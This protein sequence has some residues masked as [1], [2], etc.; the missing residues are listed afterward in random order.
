MTHLGF[1]WKLLFAF[2]ATT[3][4]A[5]AVVAFVATRL[6]RASY[7]RSD[8][9]RLEQVLGQAQTAIQRRAELAARRLTAAAESDAATRIAIALNQPAEITSGVFLSEASA[10]ARAHELELLQIIADDG[11]VLSSAQWEARAGYR[12]ADLPKLASHPA[13]FVRVDQLLSGPVLAVEV[14]REVSVGARKLYLLGGYRLDES[15]INEL[16]QAGLEHVVLFRLGG[17][18]QLLATPEAKRPLEPAAVPDTRPSPSGRPRAANGGRSQGL[19]PDRRP[20]HYRPPA[21]SPAVQ[22]ALRRIAER[23]VLTNA[24][25]RQELGSGELPQSTAAATPIRDARGNTLGAFVV[26]VSGTERSQVIRSLYWAALVAGGLGLAV[27]LVL[28]VLLANRITAPVAELVRASGEVA[29]GNLDYRIRV[30]GD[31]EM[32][33]LSEAFNRMAASL[34]D[35]RERLVQAERVAAWRELARRLA[36]E[37]NNPLFP[38]QLSIEN[39]RR[40]R[41]LDPDNFSEVF[42]E[43]TT[44]LLAELEE[45]K[46]IV[47][48]FSDF[49]KMPRPEPEPTDLRELLETTARRYEARI[50]QEN[51][52]LNLRL[53]AEPVVAHAD[54]HLI[55]QALGNLVLNALDAMPGGGQLDL[56]AFRQ[57]ARA[58]VEVADTGQGLTAE[59]QQR[60]FTPYYTTKQHGT[61]LGLAIVQSV[62]ADHGGRIT[63]ESEPQ[64]GTRFR[65]ELPLSVAS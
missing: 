46:R 7:L 30:R 23:A 57:D 29:G 5:V 16:N 4:V 17:Q 20:G 52:S 41:Q 49:A 31:D 45:L 39:L 51:V 38:L 60:L 33:R 56:R 3:V 26:T 43:G 37:L 12:E 6:L 62:V 24:D 40:A 8:Q 15:F 34:Q 14:A 59:E 10:L 32:A 18:G 1:R 47:A 65:T 9:Q 48:R 27:A 25:Y 42:E 11:T 21:R 28:S 44:T 2:G 36:H 54:P 64:K 58:V 55:G 61:G 35:H 63:V 22:E 53:A 50:R 13:A 19:A